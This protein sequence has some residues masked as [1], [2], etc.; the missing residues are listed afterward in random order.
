MGARYSKHAKEEILDDDLTTVDCE[1][2][3]RGGAVRSPSQFSGEHARLFGAPPKRDVVSLR[4]KAAP[5][6]RSLTAMP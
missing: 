1:N 6:Q 2:V 5:A 3:L 4:S